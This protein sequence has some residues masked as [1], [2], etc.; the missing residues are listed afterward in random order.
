MA[1]LAAPEFASPQVSELSRAVVT[2]E[3]MRPAIP[4]PE[5]DAAAAEKLAAFA[6]AGQKSNILLFIVDDIGYGDPGAFGGGAALGAA[7]PNMDRLAAQGL[8]LTLTYHSRPSCLA[9]FAE[10]EFPQ[11]A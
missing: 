3:N 6:R 10:G 7:T 11:L 1:L 9:G 5:Q 2:A 8:K 4:R